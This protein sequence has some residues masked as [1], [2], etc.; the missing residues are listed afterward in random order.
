MDCA[1]R[2]NAVLC[3]I[4]IPPW[5]GVCLLLERNPLQIAVQWDDVSRPSGL[6]IT[7]LN[8]PLTLS[9]LCTH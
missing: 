6:S 3:S 5:S 7:L 1:A 2:A 9:L 4:T 8:C